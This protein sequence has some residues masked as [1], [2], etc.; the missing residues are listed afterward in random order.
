MITRHYR[1]WRGT[2]AAA[3]AGL[4]LTGCLAPAASRSSD[5]G[6]GVRA[7]VPK[8]VRIAT[9]R[10]P[11]RGLAPPGGTQ[12]GDM[13][14][15]AFIF[16]AGL[17]IY[18]SLGNLQPHVAQKI[19]TLEDGD[20]A[21]FP[22]GRMELTWRLRPDVRWHD[23]VALTAEDFVFGVQIVQDPEV[24]LFRGR[25]VQAL[26]AA[27]ALDSQTLVLRWNALY[28]E[29]NASDPM[30]IP[31]VP[32]RFV[33]ELYERRDMQ[34]FINSPFWTSEWVGLGP[35]K[36][37]DW[38]LG[39][40]A[41]AAAF[42][43]FF[44]G[45]PKIDRV[46]IRYFTDLNTMV[47]NLLAA[48]VDVIPAGTI[49]IEEVMAIRSA[50][51]PR[52]GGTVLQ[53]RAEIESLRIQFRYP[54]AP[55]ATDV[56]IRR[57]LAHMTDRQALVDALLYGTTSVA[58]A[59][60]G[61][62]DPAYRLLEQRG[63]PRYPFDVTAGERLMTEA[64]WLRGGDGYASPAG[65]RFGIEFRVVANS[66]YN[67]RQGLAITDQWKAAGLNPKLVIIPALD[68]AKE[69]LKATANGIY[70]IP[71][72]LTPRVL[73][74]FTTRTISSEQSRWRGNNY[75]AYSNAAYDRLHEQFA[76]TLDAKRRQEL[77]ADLLKI[78][79]EDVPFIPTLY[80]V[81]YAT[82]FRAG[83]RGPSPLP[84]AQ[85]VSTWNIHGWDM[86]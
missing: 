10:E 58:D 23:G 28:F 74:N 81:N 43:G 49:K 59:F 42:D 78:A 45:K 57:A 73:E 84:A 71:D 67:V 51:D 18:D 41:E 35:Y 21:V 69:E 25:G 29:A 46:V 60:A 55:W 80:A 79:A 16:H 3:C 61:L 34:T 64:G 4:V 37:T 7:G 47:A 44:L 85:L 14:S 19:P 66:D 70:W 68:P 20:W 48:D 63:F 76:N 83:V 82:A 17:T 56:R 30:E 33:G 72:Q 40:H 5:P 1:G 53:S 31:A 38:V 11:V 9:L 39:S 52:G 12:F 75:G 15:V 8:T 65:A 86:D 24:P 2:V 13:R 77:K 32:A 36:L 54:V 26:D 6:T 22:D 50:W 62:D 27:I